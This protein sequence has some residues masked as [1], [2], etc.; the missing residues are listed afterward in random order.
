[1]AVFVAAIA[2]SVAGGKVIVGV[3]ASAVNVGAITLCVA[4]IAVFVAG[5]GVA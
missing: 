3:K 4:A 1:M 2:V 5:S